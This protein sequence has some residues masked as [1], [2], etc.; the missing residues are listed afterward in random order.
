M[1]K[2]RISCLCLLCLR[3]NMNSASHS[4]APRSQSLSNWEKLTRPSWSSSNSKKTASTATTRCSRESSEKCSREHI[5]KIPSKSSADWLKFVVGRIRRATRMPNISASE[6]EPNTTC[7][8]LYMWSN[9]SKH[10]FDVGKR[11]ESRTAAVKG[12]ER[13][14]H[15]V[16]AVR[17]GA[18]SRGRLG[19]SRPTNAL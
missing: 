1:R 10:S 11:K 6:G 13:L 8:I 3:G 18:S 12:L 5:E 7:A 17:A 19:E 4:Q 2:D 9:V 15:L 16:T 14:P